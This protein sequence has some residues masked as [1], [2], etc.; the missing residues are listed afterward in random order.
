MSE[1]KKYPYDYAKAEALRIIEL[2]GPHCD[3]IAI[4]GSIRR[5]RAE[6]GDIEIVCIPK[7]VMGG[8]FSD[9]PMRDPGYC[10]EVNSMT[11]IKGEPTGK[12]TQRISSNGINV[13]IFM[14]THENWGVIMAIRTGSA[15]FSAMR[16]A[17]R[18]SQLGYHSQG[19]ILY[20]NGEAFQVAE[21]SELFKMLGIPWIEPNMREIT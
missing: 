19:G 3:R 14:A 12:Y 5:E 10:S 21:E 4:A 2:I 6:V 15:A 18:W 17:A 13:D 1:G 11:K 16:I 8:L 7:T 9:E 20:K